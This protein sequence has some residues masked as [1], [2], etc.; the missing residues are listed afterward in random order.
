M[1]HLEKEAILELYFL[2]FSS[3]FLNFIIKLKWEDIILIVHYVEAQ[4]YFFTTNSMGCKQR[5]WFDLGS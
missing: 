4:H 5:G 1:E 2:F 3:Y